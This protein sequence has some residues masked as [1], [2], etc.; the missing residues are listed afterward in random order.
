MATAQGV[1]PKEGGD[2]PYASEINTFDNINGTAILIDTTNYST[3]SSSLT[4]VRS[5]TIGGGFSGK[6]LITIAMQTNG[7]NTSNYRTLDNANFEYLNS[8]G[9]SSGGFTG[10]LIFTAIVEDG[11]VLEIQASVSSGSAGI[12]DLYVFSGKYGLTA[13]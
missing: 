7:V 8:S 9:S 13:S 3:S 5:L 1:Y 12:K 4:T 6:G 2:P 11:D 10:W